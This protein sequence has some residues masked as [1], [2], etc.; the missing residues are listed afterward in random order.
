M[1]QQSLWNPKDSSHFSEASRP[2]IAPPPTPPY[3]S[4]KRGP[5]VDRPQRIIA[6]S[7]RDNITK[8]FVLEFAP[9]YIPVDSGTISKARKIT[10]E[11]AKPLLDEWEEYK[12]ITAD[13]EHK[14]ATFVRRW[15]KSNQK[16]KP[17]G[18]INSKGNYKGTVSSEQGE[19]TSHPNK[20][21][22]VDFCVF[23]WRRIWPFCC[24]RGRNKEAKNHRDFWLED[25]KYLIMGKLRWWGRSWWRVERSEISLW[26]LC[27][28]SI[29]WVSLHSE[30]HVMLVSRLGLIDLLTF[31][32]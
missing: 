5:L 9:D 8:Y 22:R 17:N 30:Q 19:S 11:E 18:L 4:T 32:L 26:N 13:W 27:L 23:N 7:V 20:A 12:K 3:I 28:I 6:E 25:N 31:Y 24:A 21:G 15:E 16:Q 1:P 2:E 10:S 29:H 14:S